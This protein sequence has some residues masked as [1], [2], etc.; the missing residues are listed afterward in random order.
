MLG[1]MMS[2]DETTVLRLFP[3]PAQKVEV[4]HGPGTVLQTVL[5][6]GEVSKADM[7]HLTDYAGLYHAAS[8]D[9]AAFKSKL[10]ALHDDLQKLAAARGES[11]HI[12]LELGYHRTDYPYRALLCFAFGLLCISLSWVK[13]QSGWAK[14]MKRAC[15]VLV[16]IGAVYSTVG[17]VIRCLI[18]ERPPITTLYET[19]LFITATAVIGALLTEWANRKGVAL[20]VAALAGTA[21]MFLSIRFMNLERTDTMQ[22]LQAVL[23]TNFWLSTHVPCINLGYTAGMVAAFFSIGYFFARM[24]RVVRHGDT[25]A[26]ELT[27]MAYAFVLAGLLLS[28]VGTVLGGIWANYSWGRFWGW[29]PKENGALM[30]VLM[31]L[32]I[33]HARLG[34]YIRETGFHTCNIVLGM[35]TVFSWFATNQL[36]VG[37]HSYGAMEGA[38]KW[39]YIF[40]GFMTV[41]LVYGIILSR[42]DRRQATTGGAV[43][44]SLAKAQKA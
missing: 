31:N 12:G 27:R 23:I 28:L 2:G 19:I 20:A 42:A 39:L 7:E 40:W 11:G 9:A 43:P 24:F 32:I 33:L 38:W 30:I 44:G 35:I 13:P 37:L 1:A 21:G 6:G 41:L 18:M 34:G 17:I 36:G 4:W 3:P 5:Q 10:K 14:W 16:G 15:F 8:G 22:Q 29:D 26:R 25:N